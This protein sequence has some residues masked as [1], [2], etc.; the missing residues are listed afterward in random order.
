[1][2]VRFEI[3]RASAVRAG[4][5]TYGPYTAELS[6]DHPRLIPE[7]R[8]LLAKL[9]EHDGIT[10]IRD[11]QNETVSLSLDDMTHADFE[12]TDPADLAFA[13]LDMA[14]VSHRN[15]EQKRRAEI[16]K[17]KAQAE[18]F[19]NFW[20]DKP[21]DAMHGGTGKPP[22][23][24]NLAGMDVPDVDY[25][26]TW[27]G[28]GAEFAAINARILEQLRPWIERAEQ[29]NIE[30]LT[31]RAARDEEAEARR[32]DEIARRDAE[33]RA[34]IAE[35][36]PADLE[37]FDDGYMPEKEYLEL[38]RVQA[39]A[40]FANYDEVNQ[41]YRFEDLDDLHADDCERNGRASV[42]REKPI[43]D[44]T[45]EEYRTLKAI[46]R[47]AEKAEQGAVTVEA[48]RVNWECMDCCAALQMPVAKVTATYLGHD[49]EVHLPLS[50][51]NERIRG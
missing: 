14:L 43:L 4:I 19:I 5:E 24:R 1:M 16:E 17:A 40:P 49:F 44:L 6:L 48:C 34:F 23:V 50:G 35:H 3:N 29:I 45:A 27:T 51:L 13:A 10:E 36:M 42:Y 18:A 8:A 47:T 28:A 11:A 2:K 25:R 30:L 7:H 32:K 38:M 15:A 9:T 22:F 39:L 12:R 41:L 31:Q 26:V 37:R 33:T 46:E 21:L 20:K